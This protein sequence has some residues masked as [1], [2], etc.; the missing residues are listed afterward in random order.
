MKRFLLVFTLFFLFWSCEFKMKIPPT[1]HP[2][3][4]N[5]PTL[6]A[7]DLSNASYPDGV[8]IYADG[9]LTASEDQ[10]IWTDQT[11]DNYVLDLEF[12]TDFGTNSGVVVYCSN[13]DNWI[14][15]SIE[16][17]IADDYAE[18]WAKSH[19]TWQCA[20]FFGRKAASKRTVKKP[21]EWNRFTI[22][23]KDNMIWVMLNGEQV[24]EMDMTK[25]TDAKVNPDGT[26]APSWLSNPPA[27]LPTKGYIGLQG[28]H[29][30][31]PVWFRNLKIKVIE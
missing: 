15:N 24:N 3:S 27:E 23:C 25:F 19:P 20:A 7:E 28:K 31:A 6:F 10:N 11:Y 9:I 2:N 8:W 21:G 12:K 1:T 17:Q 29:A 26:P 16:I 22:T 18:Q 13:K 5:W 4:K 14:P 30:G